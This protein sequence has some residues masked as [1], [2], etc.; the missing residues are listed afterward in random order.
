MPL[1]VRDVFMALVRC[2]FNVPYVVNAGLILILF[3]TSY[4]RAKTSFSDFHLFDQFVVTPLNF[5]VYNQNR[6]VCQIA[7][8]PML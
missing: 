1:S 2:L 5:L 8:V 7:S 6:L 4:Y 3:D